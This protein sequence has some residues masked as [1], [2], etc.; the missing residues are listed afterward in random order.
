[1]KLIVPKIAEY[2]KGAIEHQKLTHKSL[3]NIIHLFPVSGNNSQIFD[4]LKIDS[5]RSES[6]PAF[7]NDRM[8]RYWL[9]ILYGYLDVVMNGELEVRTR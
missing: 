2:E 5:T 6:L 3:E 8:I 9:P 1:M 7:E 4:N